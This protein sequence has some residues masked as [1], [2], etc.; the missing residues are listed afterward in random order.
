MYSMRK[1]GCMIIAVRGAHTLDKYIIKHSKYFKYETSSNPKF[2]KIKSYGR[3][4]TLIAKVKKEN[5]LKLSQLIMSGL[6]E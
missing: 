2:S 6:R 1:Q 3:D 5:L 4:A